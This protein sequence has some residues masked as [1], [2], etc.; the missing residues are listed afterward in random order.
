[1]LSGSAFN[2]LLKTLEEPPAH[3]VFILA[4]TELHKLP[5]T[6]ISRCQR[7]DFRRIAVPVIVERLEQIA[8]AESIPLEHD[9][10]IRIAR[11][12]QGG[13]RDALSLLE[14]CAGGDRTVT[15][16]VVREVTGGSSREQLASTVAA[17]ADHNTSALFAIVDEVVT[18]SRDITV[19]WQDLIAFY[20]D[21]LVM[22]ST[23]DAARYLD[24]TAAE[25]DQLAGLAARFDRE[26]ILSHTR[27]LESAL[28]TMQRS[29]SIKRMC[30]ELALLRL[31]DPRLDTTGE[32]LLER[33]AD[34]ERK[35]AM[36]SAGVVPV[37][38]TTAPA[39]SEASPS[40][41]MDEVPPAL[42]AKQPEQPLQP[43]AAS[44]AGLRG[45]SIWPEVIEQLR[46]RDPA[47]SS[48]LQRAK[49]AQTADGCIIVRL[50]NEFM[51]TMLDRPASRE[52]LLS[53]I[54]AQADTPP[55]GLRF[56]VIPPNSDAPDDR[57]FHGNR[58][59]GCL[60]PNTV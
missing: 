7:F 25:R 39:S 36:L 37:P 10:A 56:E 55:T 32:A 57:N 27:H 45:L 3:V 58:G 1:M 40:A 9:A 19:F 20:R 5:A 34:L 26:T 23:P 60:Q 35:L 43:A 54:A 29:G 44:T 33:V 46:T 51:L 30:A 18:S 38:A 50:A 24:L 42:P 17:I 16:E 48:F 13:M 12:A 4:T 52:L 59:I 15:E 31:C 53:A 21:I 41:S 22:L 49:A 6:I 14:L 11:I 2:A 28:Y 47:L 8:A